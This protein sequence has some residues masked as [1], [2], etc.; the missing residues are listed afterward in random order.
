MTLHIKSKLAEYSNLDNE[1]LITNFQSQLT[2]IFDEINY[3]GRQDE[4]QAIFIEY[5]FYYHFTSCLTCY[6]QQDYPLIEEPR[7]ITNEY[8]YNKQIL[9]IEKGVN[10]ELAWINCEEFDKL[11][12]LEVGSDLENLFKLHSR[13]LLH[14]ALD[15]LLN[16]QLELFKNRPFTFYINEHDCETM[17]LYR[18]N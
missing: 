18:L 5:D 14:R 16:R 11:D 7:Y 6:G 10:F 1:Y 9:F 12:N 4:I 15:H 13:T 17:I 8:D 2:R 3:T